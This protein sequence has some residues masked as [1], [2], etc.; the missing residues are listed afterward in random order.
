[1]YYGDIR[2]N[3][4]TAFEK[5][6]YFNN[7]PF[8]KNNV[9]EIFI[10]FSIKHKFNSMIV[11]SLSSYFFNKFL[12]VKKCNFYLIIKFKIFYFKIKN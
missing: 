7:F 11:I 4:K 3:Y 5:H 1:M 8:Q 10:N 6:I 9:F 12:K 2:L